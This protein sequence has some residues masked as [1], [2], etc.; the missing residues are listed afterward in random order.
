MWR[1]LENALPGKIT[2]SFIW[3]ISSLISTASWCRDLSKRRDLKKNKLI[4]S[5][6]FI[7]LDL[8]SFTFC[9]KNRNIFVIFD[10]KLKQNYRPG[11][12]SYKTPERWSLQFQTGDIFAD[13]F[14]NCRQFTNIC[15]PFRQCFFANMASVW[16]YRAQH[17]GVSAGLIW[18]WKWW[19]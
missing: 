16:K 18:Y 6:E 11:L 15:R 14:H 3:I 10:Q 9:S 4:Q 19:A 12:M 7:C 17:S 8:S 1:K 13:I 2:F 5:N